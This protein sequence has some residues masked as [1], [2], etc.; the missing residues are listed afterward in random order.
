MQNQKNPRLER[1]SWVATI[2]STVVAVIGLLLFSTDGSPEKIV[3]QSSGANATQIGKVE[4]DLIMGGREKADQKPPIAPESNRDSHQDEKRENRAA[5][6]FLLPEQ[7]EVFIFKDGEMSGCYWTKILSRRVVK[8]SSGDVE[9]EIRHMN[10]ESQ[11]TEDFADCRSGKDDIAWKDEVFDNMTVVCSYKRPRILA[12]GYELDIL[13]LPASDAY[14]TDVS[15]YF[16]VCHA[17]DGFSSSNPFE[18]YGYERGKKT[19]ASTI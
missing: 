18:R 9:V 14:Q 19:G 11:Y 13:N 2:A 6:N 3:M 4:G 16:A 5:Q 15:L 1:I 10:G 8:I 7:T 12:K 17:D